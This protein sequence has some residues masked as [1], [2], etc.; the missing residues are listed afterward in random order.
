MGIRDEQKQATRE[1]VV[2]SA[3]RLFEEVG[4]EETTIRM[5]AERA[6]VSVGSVFTTFESKVDIFNYILFEKFEALF[7]ELQRIAPYLK[8]SARHRIA[9]LISIAYGVECQQLSLMIS[10]LAASHGWPVRI[11]VEHEKRRERLI[12]LF[13]EVLDTGVAQGEVQG[14]ADLDL[15]AQLLHDIYVRNY[16]RAYYDRL[17]PEQLSALTERQLEVLFEGVTPQAEAGRF[18]TLRAAQVR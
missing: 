4:Y 10:H 6:G 3:R 7:G 13:R 9:S 12:G 2:E 8:G 1:R 5:V 15:F 11:E 14:G 17:T 18:Q 16:R